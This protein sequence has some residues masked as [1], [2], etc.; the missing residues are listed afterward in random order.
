MKNS[1]SKYILLVH[2]F[3]AT[4]KIYH[5][6]VIY[7]NSWKKILFGYEEINL[8]LL[9][10]WSKIMHFLHYEYGTITLNDNIDFGYYFS[11]S[12]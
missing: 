1:F 4:C 11:F 2:C 5:Y 8:G 9:N 3:Y 10:T 12:L 6:P 7:D